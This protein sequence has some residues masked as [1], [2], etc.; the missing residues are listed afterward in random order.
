[1][2]TLN[3]LEGE[4]SNFHETFDKVRQAASNPRL[5]ILYTASEK[6]LIF[7]DQLKSH[8]SS[9]FQPTNMMYFIF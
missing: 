4:P 5:E 7:D 1:M 2:T 6:Y 3:F 9:P 8:N